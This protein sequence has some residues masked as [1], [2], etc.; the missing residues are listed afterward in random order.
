GDGTLSAGDTLASSGTTAT[1]AAVDGTYSLS[2]TPGKYIVCEV[3]Q[4]DWIQSF[5]ASGGECSSNAALGASGYAIT[6]TSNQTDSGNDFGNYQNATKTGVKFNDLDA[7]GT[8]DAGEPGL[9]GWSIEAYRDVDASGTLSAGDTLAE[10]GTTATLLGVDGTYTLSLTPGK[11]VVCEVQQAGW[12]Q[13]YPATGGQCSSDAALG[14]NGYAITLTSHQLDAGN[15]FGN[16]QN[17]TK[18][19]VKFNDLNANGV[20]DAGEPGLNGWVINAYKDVDASGTLSAGDTFDSTNT[21]A[22]VATV[23]GTYSLSLKPGKYIIC[24]VMQTTWVQ[25]YPS[26][27]ACASN[28]TLG[29]AGWAITLT[30]GQLD[31]DN[32]FGNTQPPSGQGCTPGFWQGGLGVTLWN[33]ANDPQWTSHGGA[34]T[35]PFT[36]STL[37]NSFFTP[38]SKT[39]GKTMLQIVG[40]G[41]GSDWYNKVARDVIAAYLN[42]SFGLTQFPYTTAQISAAWTNAVTGSQQMQKLQALHDQLAPANQLGCPIT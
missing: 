15:D 30:S 6:L 14:A 38:T 13:S 7:D 37:F 28:S 11:Y 26:G 41:G 12:I 24:E 23:D 42:A 29:A 2:L 8:K 36:T 21:T 22:T 31:A 27:T 40:S 1:V 4:T 25:T 10:T 16:Y 32:N 3:Q 19:G 17:A 35:N 34:G 5:P 33:Q 20:K 9:N 18:T 39:A